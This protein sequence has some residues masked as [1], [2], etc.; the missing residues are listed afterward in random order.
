MQNFINKVNRA[1]AYLQSDVLDDVGIQAVK[2][3]KQSFHDEAF[4]NASD[5][6]MPWQE[7]KRRQNG[8]KRKG[9]SKYSSRKILTGIHGELGS[10]IKHL[11]QGRY[12]AIISPKKYAE[13]H[14][15]GGKAGRGKGFIMPKR[16]FIGPSLVLSQ[17]IENKI[18]Q[19][20]TNIFK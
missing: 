13:I 4:S 12:V 18:T 9:D 20:F 6:D 10:S 11:P 2:H 19:R 17:K 7:V 16:Q 15:L 1:A 3:F 5:K 14:N 8:L